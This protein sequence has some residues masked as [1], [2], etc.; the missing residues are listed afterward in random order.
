MDTVDLG[1][2]LGWEQVTVLHPLGGAPRLRALLPAQVHLLE[3]RGHGLADALPYGFATLLAAGFDRVILVGS[4]NPT[5]PL[6]ARSNRPAAP[7][8]A[9][10]CASARAPTAAT[11]CSACTSLHLGV[12]EVIDWSTSRV[13]RQTLAHAAWLGLR[14]ATLS[15]W[16]DVDDPSDLR[17]PSAWA[18][19]QPRHAFAPHTRG[20]PQ[21]LPPVPGVSPPA[22]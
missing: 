16:Y 3:Q 14:V 15:E 21:P 6:G 17:P 2:A 18:R 10:T 8:T 5:L 7:W 22:Q 1:L 19:R 9:T 11:T 12:F 20:R 4:D 13:Y